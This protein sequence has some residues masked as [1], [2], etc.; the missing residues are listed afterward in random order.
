MPEAS[1]DKNAKMVYN[2]IAKYQG[3][4]RVPGPYTGGC[5]GV[6]GLE[7]TYGAVKVSTG[8]LRYDKRGGPGNPLNCP[9]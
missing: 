9:T 6:T 5:V 7:I 8:I 1:I 3:L 4:V 2:Y